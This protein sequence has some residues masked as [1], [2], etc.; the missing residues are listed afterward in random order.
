[1]KP[2]SVWIHPSLVLVAG[3]AGLAAGAEGRRIEIADLHKIVRVA[4]PHLAP[5][6]KSIVCVVSR[7]NV[8]DDRWDSELA[9]VDV[10]SGQQRSLTYGRKRASSP[11][12]SPSGDRL[13]FIAEAGA[14]QDANPQIFALPMA[15][16]EARKI[17]EATTGV[18]QFAWRPDGRDL[19]FVAADEPPNKKAIEAHDDAFEVEYEDYLATERAPP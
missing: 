13:A 6:G 8:P 17:S 1:M 4:D 9:L 2:M 7:A 18:E 12:W 16:G 3:C 19:A 10:A 11:R 15:G 5:D 14:G